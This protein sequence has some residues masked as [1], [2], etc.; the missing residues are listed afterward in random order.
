M[1]KSKGL[2]R[3]LS[4]LLPTAPKEKRGASLDR[5]AHE[6]A[7]PDERRVELLPLDRV[8]P[9]PEQPRQTFDEAAMEELAASVR[10]YGVL[11]PILVRPADGGYEIVA[12]E[13]RYRGAKLAGL[14]EIP[15]IVRAF[16]PLEMAEVAIIENV[17]REDLNVIEEAQAYRVLMHRFGLTQAELSEKVGAS[18]S[19]IAN[20]LRLLA[21]PEKVQESLLQGVLLMGQARP[22][23]SLDTPEL[24]QKAADHIA[25]HNLSAREAEQLVAKLKR[26]PTFLDP[27]EGAKEPVGTGKKREVFIEDAEDKL[28][29]FFGAPV[30]IH[31]GTTQSRI[32]VNFK[33]QG[34]LDR[35][36]TAL[37]EVHTESVERKKTLLREVSRR[38]TT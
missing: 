15:A 26:D 33:D 1:A 28:K 37:G 2:G 23:L 19:H 11:Q 30:H 34:D 12:G 35:I 27:V 31:V 38:F 14:N 18:R 16:N 24:V 32:V 4:A 29:M 13:R 21:L 3:G 8:R 5:V 7:H 22:L 6:A 10:Q 17:Q 25:G 20:I 9:N 36:V